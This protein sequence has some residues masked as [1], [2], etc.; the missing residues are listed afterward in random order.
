[1]I[2]K[3]DDFSRKKRNEKKRKRR[4]GWGG[5]TIGVERVRL[6]SSVKSCATFKIFEMESV[7]ETKVL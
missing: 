4:E 2:G 3:L 1:M 7:F 6:K 5:R